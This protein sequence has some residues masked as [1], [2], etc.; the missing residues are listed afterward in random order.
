[1]GAAAKLPAPAAART[2]YQ[3]F[4]NSITS[5]ATKWDIKIHS[6]VL[7]DTKNASDAIRTAAERMLG[8]MANN[9]GIPGNNYMPPNDP[10]ATGGPVGPPSS[11][12]PGHL[13]NPKNPQDATAVLTLAS[14]GQNPEATG[15]GGT[16]MNGAGTYVT[17]WNLTS[18]SGTV[19]P[20][21]YGSIINQ[22][23]AKYGV[24]P[25]LIASIMTL[26]TGG[27]LRDSSGKLH[28]PYDPT[29]VSSSGAQGLMQLMPNTLAS[30]VK[31]D[32]TFKNANAFDPTTNI[33]A[34]TKYLAEII[35]GANERGKVL[36]PKDYYSIGGSYNAGPSGNFGNSQTSS[37]IANLT[38]LM[39]STELELT[40]SLVVINSAGMPI[41]TANVTGKAKGAH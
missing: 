35:G 20:S 4:I 18:K 26:E 39:G 27:Q 21:Q 29:D 24:D 5:A 10:G 16:P 2:D 23:A 1:M 7:I 25:S 40:G 12:K 36:D 11:F 3:D 17:G 9:G 32:P 31:G 14:G 22:A 37:Y 13:V 34:G 6:Q 41:G 28:N 15:P 33:M 30:L 19:V 38:K 8:I